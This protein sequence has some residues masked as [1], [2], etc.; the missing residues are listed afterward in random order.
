MVGLL[1]PMASQQG[2]AGDCCVH[3]FSDIDLDVLLVVQ[4]TVQL[5]PKMSWIGVVGQGLAPEIDC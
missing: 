5:D 3:G 2:R 4:K 1:H